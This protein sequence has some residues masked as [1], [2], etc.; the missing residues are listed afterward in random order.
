MATDRGYRLSPAA[1]R[2]LVGI[3]RYTAKRWSVVQAESYQ[4]DLAAAFEG[5]ASGRKVGRP[6]EVRRS[7]YLKYAVDAHMI[8]F[9]EAETEIIV[10]RILH[11]KQ[12]PQRHL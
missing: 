6:V 11:S 9:R 10:V 4:D 8:Y 1:D 12:D 7:G 2:D 5:L 3:W